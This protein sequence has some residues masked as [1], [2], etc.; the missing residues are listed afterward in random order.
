MATVRTVDF[1][2]EIFQTPV[3]KQFLAATL[4]QLVQEPS[5]TKSQGFIGEKV[6]PGINPTDKY[7]IEPSKVRNEYQLEPGVISLV[8]DSNKIADAIT[9]PGINDAI[10]LQGGNVDNANRLYTSQY[11]SWDPFV[12]FDKMVNFSQYYWLPDGPNAVDVYATTYPLSAA[13]NVTRANG[14][15]TFSGVN[16]DNPSITLVRGGNYKF[17]VAQ[18]NQETINF[19]VTNNANSAYV[20][21]YQPN[22]TL[23]L[24]R[25]NTYVFTLSLTGIY[26]FYIKTIASLGNVNLYST[27]VTNN[28]ATTGTVTFT[29]PQDA[30]DTL[31]YACSTEFNLRGEINIIDATPGTGP[32]FWIQSF[33]GVNGRLPNAPNISSRDVLG[34]VNNGEDLGTVEF[35]VPFKTAQSFY[36]NLTDIGTVDLVSDSIQFDQINNIGITEFFAAYPNGIDGITNLNN[37][38]VIFTGDNTDPLEGGWQNISQF[39]PLNP[40]APVGTPGSFDSLPF[41]E[42]QYITDPAIQYSVWQIQ[43]VNGTIQLNSIINVNDLE[44]FTILFGDQWAQTQWYKDAEGYFQKIPLLTAIL[45]TIYYQD[46]TDPEIFGHFNLIDQT[47]DTTLNVD[48]I[49]GTKNYTSPNGVVFTNGLKVTFTGTVIPESYANN[50]YYVEGVGTGIQLLPATNFV[51]PELYTQNFSVPYDSTPFDVGGYDASLNV[52][53]T[54]DYITINRDSPDLNP[55]SRSNRW[56]HIEV[57]NAS[58]S[59]NN[60]IPVTD[61]AYRA[62]RPILEFRGGTK[63]FDFG[64]QGKQPVNVIDFDETDAFSNIEGATSYSIDGYDLEDGSL[65][66]FAADINANVRNKIYEV[67][68]I[69]PDSIPPLIAEPI[70]NLIPATDSLVLPN[71]STVCLSGNTL[72]GITFYYDGTTWIESQQKTSVNQPPLFDIYDNDGISFS[73]S[74]KYP[75]STF[76]GSKLFSY[77]IGSGPIDV[78]LGFSLSY[79]SI[80]NI[81]DIVFENNLYNDTFVYVTDSVGQT[82]PIST[83][84]V[85]Q[86]SNRIDY[87]KEIGWQTGITESLVRQQFQFTYDGKPLLLDVAVT[88]NKTV[89]P[90]KLYVGSIYKELSEYSY[91][92]SANT[93]TIT[94]K[95]PPI[96]GT[97]IEVD[98]L[99]DQISSTAFYQVPI[100]LENNPFNANSSKFSLGTIRAHYETIAENLIPFS[101]PINGSNNSRDLGNLVPYGLKILQQ[102]SPLSLA[103]YFMRSNQ[104]DIFNSLEYNS[105]EYIKYKSKL[106]EYVISN[107]LGELTVPE[108]LDKAIADITLGK[109]DINPFYWSDMLPYGPNYTDLITVINPITTNVF[110]TG[111]MYDFTSANYQGLLV[112]ITRQI[113]PNHSETTLLEKGVEYIVSTVS[114]QVIVLAPLNVG[115]IVTIREYSNTAGNF[116]PNTP[117]KM[118]LYPKFRPEVFLD[119]SYVNPAV[120]IRGHDGSITIAFG[121]IRDQVLLEFE[122]RIFNNLKTDDNPIPLTIDQVLPGFF[123]KTDYTRAEI[124]NMFGDNFLGWV[125]WNKLNYKEQ[126]YIAN[127]PFTYNYSSA[128]SKLDPANYTVSNI[129]EQPLPGAWRGIYQYFY[130]TD[131]PNT[132]PWEMLGFSEKPLWW[133]ERYGP[134]PYTNGN[135]VLWGDLESGYIADPANPRIDP[136]YVRPG[137]TNVIPAGSEGELLNPLDSVVGQYN[138]NSFVKSWVVGDGGPVEYSWWASS[139]YPFAVMRVLAI[140]RPAEFFSLFADRDLYRYNDAL[141]QY[142]Y[143]GRYRLD[144]NGLE[145]YGNGTSKASYINW[146]ID[147]NRQLGINSTDTLTVDLKNLDVRLCYRMA[148]FSDKQYLK[149]YTE[150]SSP[151]SV[152]SGQLLPPESFNVLVYKNQPYDYLTYSALII[153]IQENGY[154]IYGYDTLTPYFEIFASQSAGALI[155][156]SAGGTSVRVPNQYTQS[157]VQVPYGYSLANTTMV[158]DFILSYGRF[159]ESRGMTFTQVENGYVLNWMQMAQEFLYFSQQ[160]W[161]P[162]TILNLNPAATTFTTTRPGDIVDTIESLTPENM[163]LNQNRIKLPTRDLIIERL[164]N[165]LS[166]TSLTGQTISFIRLKFTNIENMIVFDNV[167]IFNDLIYDPVTAARQERLKMDAYVTTDW[168]G[169]LN[170]PGFILNQNNIEQWVPN[171]KYTKGEIVI[172]KNNYWSAMNIVQPKEKFDYTDWVKSNYTAIQ[173]GLLPNIPNQADQLANSY[174]T[175]QANLN[176]DNDL[177]SFGLIGFRPRQYMEALN[178]DDISQVNIYQQFLGTKGTTRAAE[179][180]TYADLGKETGTYDIFENWAVLSSTYGANADRSFVEFQLNESLLTSNPSTLQVINPQE[181]SLA[182]QTVYIND[183]W[184]SSTVITSPDIFPTTYDAFTDTALPSAG[185]V[186]VNDVDI[187][188]FSLDDPSSISAN[189]DNI[190]V[191]TTIWAAKSNSYNW[192]VYRCTQINGTITQL[193]DN[194]NSTSIVNFT[195]R[196]NLSVGDLIIIRYISNAVDGVYRVLGVPSLTSIIIAFSFVNTNQTVINGNGLS[197]YLQTSRV[198]QASDVANLPYSKLLTPG[199]KAWVDN[200]GEGHW[201]VLEKQQPFTSTGLILSN[202][203]TVNSKFGTSIAQ[204][205]NNFSALIGS[206]GSNFSTGIVY[207]YARGSSTSGTTSNYSY[208]TEIS[209]NAFGTR[210]F[211]SSISYG[212]NE[213]SVVGAPGSYS[214]VGYA[215]TLYQ[216]PTTTDFLQTQLFVP[217]DINTVSPVPEKFGTSVLMS[218]DQRWMF[219]GAP[220]GNKVYAYGQID[221]DIEAASYITTGGTS[222][223]NYSNKILINNNYPQQLIVTLNETI[224]RYNIDYTVTT[225]DIVLSSTPFSGQRLVISRRQIVQLDSELYVS[226]EPTGGSGSNALFSVDVVRGAYNVTAVNTGT[227]YNIGDVLT[228]PGTD[229]GGTSP[230]NDAVITVTAV[231][232]GGEI[233]EFTF[234]GTGISTTN[235]FNLQDYFYPISTITSFSIDVDGILQRP[236]LDYTFDDFTKRITF[237][238]IP[239]L[240]SKIRAYCGTHYKYITTLTA[241]GLASDA[242]F[243]KSVTATDDARQ[244]VIGSPLDND[245]GSLRSGASYVFDRVVV[246]YLVTDAAQQAYYI[247]GPE[248]IVTSVTINGTFLSNKEINRE[249]QFSIFGGYVIIDASIPLTIGDN[250]E[251]ETST[252]NLIQKLIPNVPYDESAFGYAVEMCPDND[253]VYIGAPYD[254]SILVQAGSVERFI[255]QSRAY[256]VITSTIANPSLTIGDTIRVNNIEVPVDP[257]N[258]TVAGLAQ[259]I[260]DSNIPNVVASTT[261]DVILFGDGR[262]QTFDVGNIY[263]A[264]QSYTPILYVDDTLQTLNLDYTYNNTTQQVNFVIAPKVKSVITVVSGRLTVTIKNLGSNDQYL[265]SIRGLNEVSVLPGNTGVLF[266]ELGFNTFIWGQ[267][268][269]SPKVT[270]Y[271]RFG[272]AVS[273]DSDSVNLVVGAPN[274]NVYAPVTFDGGLTYFDQHSTTFYSPIFNGG[275]AYTYDLLPS[276]TSSATNPG[277]FVFGQQ[278]YDSNITSRDEFGFAVNYTGGKL[279]IGSPRDSRDGIEFAGGVHIFN[280]DNNI[281]AWKIIHVQEPSVNANLLV[282]VFSYDKLVSDTQTYYDFINPLQGKILGAAARNIDYI[283]AVDP[284]NYNIGPIHNQ[285][286]SWGSEQVG[287]I[288]WDTDNVRFLDPNQNDIV[289]ASRRWGTVFPGSSVDVYQWISSTVPPTGYVGPGVP[290]STQSYAVNTTLSKQNIFETTYYFWVR[291]LVTID[292]TAG[293]TLS[294]T[295]I[296]RYIENPRASGIPYIAVLDASTFAIYN[297]TNIISAQDTILHIE[298][299][300]TLNSACIHQEYELIA[301][302]VAKAFLSPVLYQKLQDSFCGVDIRGGLVPDP[303]LPPAERYGVQYRPRQSMFLD[304]FA[305]LQNY[306]G[307]SNRILAQYPITEMRSF[308]LLNASDPVPPALTGT[309]VNWNKQVANLEELSYQDIAADPEGYRYLVDTDSSQHG[310]WTIYE[311]QNGELVLVSIENYDVKQYWSYI[312]WYKP[313]YNSSSQVVTQVPNYSSLETL[314]LSVAPIGS[315]VKVTANAQGKFEIYLRTDT[316]WDRV[317]LQDGTI[318]FSES[319]WNYQYGRFGFDVEVFDAQ[320]YAQDPVIETR[321]IIQAINEDLFIDDLEIYRNQLLMTMFEFIYSEFEAPEWLFKTSLIDVNHR[322]RA[323]APFQIYQPDNQTFVLDYINEVKPYHDVIREFNLI[324]YGDDAYPG[325][326]TDF[327]CPSRWNPFLE[328][329]QYVSPVLLPYDHAQTTVQSDV[330]DTPS[331]S[332][333]WTVSPWKEWYNNYLLGIQGVVIADGGSGYTIPPVVI[334]TGECVEQASMTAVINS[335]GQVVAVTIDN[336]GAGYLTTAIIELV[337]GNG[338]GAKAAALMGNNLVRSIKTVIKYDRYQYTTSIQQWQPYIVY[339]N[340]T[341]ARYNNV[342]WEASNPIGPSVVG[343]DFDPYQWTKIDA[344]RLSGVDRTMGYYTP[345]VNQPGLYLPL[346]IDGIDYPGVQVWGVPFNN[347]Q[348]QGYDSV[349]FDSAIVSYEPGSYDYDLPPLELDVAYSSSYLDLYLGKLPDSLNIAGGAYV[350]AYESH[351]PE[352]L[353]PGIE[354]DTMDL[355]VYTRPGGDWYQEGHGFPE[356][357]IKFAY[358]PS[359]VSFGFIGVLE[360]PVGIIVTNQNTGLQLIE[361][362]NYLVDWNYESVT[363]TSGAAFNDVIVIS[364]YELG[365]GNQLFKGKYTSLTISDEIIIPVQTNQLFEIA[366]FLNGNVYNDFTYVADGFDTKVTLGTPLSFNDLLTLVA[367]GPTTVNNVEI[368]FSW[369][370]PVTQQITAITGSSSYTLTNSMEYTNPVNLIV[371]LNGVRIQ[372]AAGIEYIGDGVQTTFLLPERLG[373]DPSLISENQVAVYVDNH[374]L[375]LNVEFVV[376]PSDSSN[377]RTVTL[378]NPPVTGSEVLITTTAGAACYV[379]GDQ[380]YFDPV[381]G[382]SPVTGDTITVTSWNDTREQNILTEVFVGPVDLNVVDTEGYDTTLFD[383]GITN[384]APGSYDYSNANLEQ[385]NDLVL[386]RKVTDPSRLWVTLNGHR[387]FYGSG[388]TL[389]NVSLTNTEIVLVSGIMSATDVVMVTEF[390]NV[391]VQEASAFRIFQD[392]RGVQAT[393]LITPQTTTTLAQPLSS[394]DEIIYV[395][396]ASKLDQPTPSKNLWGVITIDGERIMYRERDIDNNTISSL[397]RGTAGTG[398]ADHEVNASVYSMGRGELAAPF[399]QNYIVSETT[400]GDG[401]TTIFEAVNIVLIAGDA[402]EG[403]SDTTYDVGDVTGE[404]G[405]YDYSSGVPNDNAVQVYVGGTLQTTGYSVI[406]VEPV[407]VLFEVPPAEGVDVTILV[408]RA[409][410]WNVPTQS[411]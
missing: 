97:V 115:D 127:N 103:G 158:V 85:Y 332:E 398:A 155:T 285:G 101:G 91:I 2:P 63:L 397:L 51:T 44:K 261:S 128:G 179:I 204:N 12:D 295:A 171:K 345:T 407:K 383:V 291:G 227:G 411:V 185:Y 307:G 387:L 3:N 238:T 237:I 211:G 114:P 121:D 181:S 320:Y 374:P 140:T 190:G 248:S 380:L 364:V 224:L 310:N 319:L 259:Y 395:V 189:I 174:D 64:T 187:M 366:M 206:P 242:Q 231:T 386:S 219:I 58:A 316:G 111:Q 293:K 94:L 333:V 89:P 125:G 280:N 143:N 151:N 352:E 164:D 82:L 392:M 6:G 381:T 326:M 233:A 341:L 135:L 336:P 389:S 133:E 292:V 390:T 165:S 192:N 262:T 138:P 176:L 294:T 338:Q 274:G 157:V 137:L 136:L 276:A 26:P 305:A 256:G 255:N 203:P 214:N 81:G 14:V 10:K 28:G 252:F 118:G 98:V 210:E 353:V 34:V 337:G 31:Y 239:G 41:A 74:V 75:S 385:I 269:V 362:L 178:L 342:V 213:W 152:N 296:A 84:F 163:I 23:T 145:I 289:Y 304:R 324:Y 142:L 196:H 19:R 308:A 273:I 73:N 122:Q 144:A 79:L 5:F 268:I 106:L 302:G 123:R 369:S 27:G 236:R 343:P 193:V 156:V 391:I 83:G 327:D 37:R 35:N 170:A 318:Q 217:E 322:I 199:A 325:M 218:Y 347:A 270:D 8:P 223:Y 120:V 1:L 117:T 235:T 43:Y 7:V 110:N 36:Y 69:V 267:T 149:I 161:A 93:T 260:N 207:S 388:F 212:Q 408:R 313:G 48:E 131:A 250:I 301:D 405:S 124:V 354:F 173:K 65:V 67:Q 312:N 24:V 53:A 46:G 61:N 328:V 376:D 349:A 139:S 350:D 182:N 49:I 249:G 56:F 186:D 148:G 372:S 403:Y 57:I 54:P 25:G 39:D 272:S 277:L 166:I 351:A 406:N 394:T 200:N 194:L 95:N 112:Y 401:S 357:D 335:A 373:I 410:I 361:G 303:N 107:D 264:A 371:A 45:D 92:T 271:A 253:E 198:K 254:G 38:T 130:D 201:E 132:R 368:D 244:I 283:G 230:A 42:V 52:P 68:F 102:S 113:T 382:V 197:F 202:N 50:S 309:T 169:Q 311:V 105:R 348:I 299:N 232:S 11:Y 104:Y 315:S 367:I 72:Q 47:E 358:T 87:V 150:R 147:Y 55:W 30:P 116:V 284:A 76:T 370:A 100:N 180:F 195:N 399:Y 221:V 400:L 243:G 188:V 216:I 222:S 317:G 251:I 263:S 287:L 99:S 297:A 359:S 220:D 78:I 146:I 330:S 16:G 129:Y 384:N 80:N 409:H 393:Y 9:Y 62:K 86:Y 234:T 378:S 360:Y 191:G 228:I 240:G 245:N 355:R 4:D 375:I 282:S 40:S 288:W 77:A 365:G 266:N 167:S 141:G 22:P 60:E 177:L 298:F 278:I 377:F 126:D 96:I 225:T 160:G 363:I 108:I 18:N 339:V 279:L 154:A 340:G 300:Q 109:T 209:L 21:N 306:L 32:G 286:N 281:P 183:I 246:R 275:V 159:L 175:Y 344:S 59:Y 70:I 314:T 184:R 17:N 90:I 20:I 321:F 88:N 258:P 134:A 205:T 208:N 15:Y 396:D 229:I 290:L 215:L 247:P 71:Q 153:E 29:V 323:L 33:P 402:Y 356:K 168:N 13:F 404:P 331:N 265:R 172:Y 162:G 241:P 329:P 257:A 226:L 334:V 66:I 346:L 119:T 379:I